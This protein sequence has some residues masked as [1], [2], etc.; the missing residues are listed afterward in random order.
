MSAA[1]AAIQKTS[2]RADRTYKVLLERCV[3]V[4]TRVLCMLSISLACFC[5]SSSSSSS[6][7][8]FRSKRDQVLLA[9]PASPGKSMLLTTTKTSSGGYT[10]LLRYLMQVGTQPASPPRCC[11]STFH[12]YPNS[13]QVF[14][15]Y[16]RFLEHIRSDPWTAHKYASV[17]ASIEEEESGGNDALMMR[18]DSASMLESVNEKT[19]AVIVI[20]A[21]GLSGWLASVGH[22]LSLIILLCTPQLVPTC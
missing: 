19:S 5:S 13:S 17:A 2:A 12:R 4:H 15:G 11:A 18:D 14:R 7:S 6:S 8:R 3:S 16:A 20:N 22:S 1:L 9:V 10:H 21:E